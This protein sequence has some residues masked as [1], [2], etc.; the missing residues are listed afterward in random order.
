MGPIIVEATISLSSVIMIAAGLSFIGLG[1]EPPSP[2]WGA[3]LSDSRE[4]MR[5]A[6]WLVFAPGLAIVVTALAFNLVGDGVR[7][8]LDPR[9]K[10]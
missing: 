9:Q 10:K 5:Q 1:V 4:Y 8:A 3:M 7:D 6:P 2:E